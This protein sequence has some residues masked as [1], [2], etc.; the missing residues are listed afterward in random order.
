MEHFYRWY[1]CYPVISDKGRSAGNNQSISPYRTGMVAYDLD[2][3]LGFELI[4]EEEEMR[5]KAVRDVFSSIGIDE[6]F[7]NVVLRYVDESMQT[8][9]SW[10]MEKKLVELS[11]VILAEDA[12]E[13]LK[14]LNELSMQDFMEIQ[15]KLKNENRKVEKR[16]KDIGNEAMKLFADNDLDASDFYQG[17]RG[18]YSYLEKLSRGEVKGLNSYACKFIDDA[19]CRVSKKSNK[20][21]LLLELFLSISIP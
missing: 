14:Q 11:K 9:K 17:N 20:Q 16:C 1:S 3:P 21:E 4:L 5:E 10:N 8:D 7:T 18:V 15:D 19:N 12:P 6:G 2:I 13:K